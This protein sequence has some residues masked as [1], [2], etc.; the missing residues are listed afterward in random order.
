MKNANDLL[1]WLSAKKSGTWSRYRTA[2]DELEIFEEL[3]SDDED[4]GEDAPDNFGLPIYHRL[5]LNL[6]RLGHAE[7]FRKDFKNGWRVVPPTLAYNSNKGKTIGVLC[8]ARTDHMLDK[9]QEE[10]DFHVCVTPQNECP[11]RI[12]ILTKGLSQKHLEQLAA[13]TNLYLQANTTMMLLASVPPVDDHQYR[14]PAEMPFG[15]DW[16]VHR[17]APE[18]LKWLA[19][20]PERAR[21]APFGLHRFRIAY[22]LQY[23]ISLYGDTYK[24]PVQVGK[25]HLLR[26]KKKLV[27]SY[28]AE[29]QIFS[30]P[31]ICRPP[32]LVDRALTLCSGLIPSIE[33]GRLFYGNVSSSVAMKAINL[34]RQ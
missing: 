1:L 22:R 7:F 30:L 29:N 18:S 24:I 9:L 11:D 2:V 32:L 12:E 21:T 26:M 20:T 14:T 23:Y 17:F 19:T 6:E 27:V 10:T 8:G 34:L 5:R 31:V 15:E 4:L 3:S 33:G 16:E 13:S 25:Y 28:N